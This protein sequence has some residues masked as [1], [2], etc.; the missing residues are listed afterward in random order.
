M[1]G[2]FRENSRSCNLRQSCRRIHQVACPAAIPK[3]VFETSKGQTS[4]TEHPEKPDFFMF[5]CL[6]ALMESSIE[7]S[8]W[9]HM[10]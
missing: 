10:T 3:A 5:K 6:E 1:S 9:N 7:Y 8:V 4:E 2:G